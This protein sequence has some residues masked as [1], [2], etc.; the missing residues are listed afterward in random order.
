[1]C[2]KQI[3]TICVRRDSLIYIRSC[4]MNKRSD[5]ASIRQ[6]ARGT[7]KK[8]ATISS[9]LTQM[10][11]FAPGH[12]TLWLS[13]SQT[14]KLSKQSQKQ[15]RQSLREFDIVCAVTDTFD[16]RRD[17]AF[18]QHAFDSQQASMQ[19]SPQPT[20]SSSTAM[21]QVQSIF[22]NNSSCASFI[23]RARKIDLII[24]DEA[25]SFISRF[26]LAARRRHGYRI[27]ALTKVCRVAKA[28]A[29]LHFR[30]QV[31]ILDFVIAIMLQEESYCSV[32][33]ATSTANAPTKT[34]PMLQFRMLPLDG[35]NLYQCYDGSTTTKQLK[36]L[37][38]HIRV[39][40]Q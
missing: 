38:D 40:I 20:S 35:M 24:D 21:Q 23:R 19:T 2:S 14:S 32:Q 31:S 18:A 39:L 29:R 8:Q 16:P 3:P 11:S 5:M 33:S 22:K 4:D 1:M 34:S 12:H 27:E 37:Y 36:A 26:F 6:H 15:L 30:C 10:Y 7:L 13:G 9:A 28:H 17:E 25:N